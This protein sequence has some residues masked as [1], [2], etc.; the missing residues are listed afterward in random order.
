MCVD[1]TDGDVVGGAPEL[2]DVL[3]LVRREHILGVE[4]DAEVE[5]RVGQERR[6]GRRV[7]LRDLLAGHG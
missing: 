6:V 7:G 2:F 1:V 4:G 3:N 5:E